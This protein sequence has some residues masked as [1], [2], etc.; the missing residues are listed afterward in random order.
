MNVLV[1]DPNE[2]SISDAPIPN[3]KNLAAGIRNILLDDQTKAK[4]NEVGVEPP[5]SSIR[6]LRSF[7]STRPFGEKYNLWLT[8]PEVKAITTELIKHGWADT[9]QR[10]YEGQIAV[11]NRISSSSIAKDLNL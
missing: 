3:R 4:L 5:G 10:E 9:G 7:L 11:W 6:R 8:G 1:A 2:P